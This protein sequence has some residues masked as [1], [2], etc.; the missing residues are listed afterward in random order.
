MRIIP[1]FSILSL[2]AIIAPL[3]RAQSDPNLEIGLKP[4]GAYQMGNIDNVSLGNGS[5]AVDIPLISY[6]QRGGKLKLDF[7]L[8]YFD[9]AYYEEY[10][11][12]TKYCGWAP[13]FVSAGMA[14][15]DKQE[16]STTFTAASNNGLSPNLFGT[17]DYDGA[18][19]SL[20]AT[21]TNLL[22]SV[23]AS[24]YQ[25]IGGGT[26]Y[27]LTSVTDKDG[28][29]FT[30]VGATGCPFGNVGYSVV[31]PSG[32]GFGSTLPRVCTGPRSDP[33]GNKISFS[34]S[35]G[36]TDTMGRAIPLPTK[37]TSQSDF[38]GCTGS[39]TTLFVLLW[40]PPGL[41]GGTY[42]L[43]FCYF[44][45]NTTATYG[46]NQ[47]ELQSVVL[48]DN[49]A[50]TFQYT[51][52]TGSID[53][54]IS[55]ITFPTG[56]TLSYTWTTIA[57]CQPPNQNQTDYTYAVVTRTL[58]PNDGVTP[59]STWTYT[60][61]ASSYPVQ[62]IVSAPP[63]IGSTPD[64]TVHTIGIGTSPQCYLYETQAQSYQG[65]HTSG[66]L[67][68]TT[69]TTYQY[70]TENTGS[71]ATIVNIAPTKVTTSWANGQ[72]SQNSFT[73]D[74]AYSFYPSFGV[75]ISPPYTI[76][77]NGTKYQGTYG[78]NLTK[79]EYD[80][81]SG[82]PGA[83][84]R[85]TTTAYLALSNSTY[86]NANLL[87]LPSSVQVTGSGPGSNTTYNYDETG[88]PAGAHGNL[89]STHRWLN[90][91][92]T[93]LVASNVY[94]SNGL[95]TSTTDPKN[96]PPTTY[97][98]SP[99][100]CPA[101]SGYAGDGP[102]SVTNA[103]G[104]T[105]Y[106]CYDLNTGPLISTTD[107]NGETTSY[108]Y[109]DMIRTTQISY[110]D[111]G[112]TTFT[113]FP[114]FQGGAYVY[115]AEKMDTSGDSRDI[116]EWVDGVGRKGRVSISNGETLDYDETTDICYNGLGQVAFSAYPF[117]D[118]GWSAP[119]S[120]TI[121][122]DSF[123]YD[124]LGRTT[125]VTHSDGSSVLTSYTGR[126]TSVSDEGNGNGTQRVQRVS[127]VDGL[128]RLT[129]LCEVTNATL[130][131]GISGSTT[132]AACGQDIAETGF[133]TTYAYD[134]LNDPT[135]VTQGPLNP[136]TFVY[137]SLARL[138]SGANPE[139]G[140]T[141]YTYDADS[142]LLTKTDARSITTTYAYDKLNRML[143]KIH[144]DG[145]IQANFQYDA[146][147][148]WGV[149]L[150]NPIGRL[151][152]KW[153]S[154]TISDPT[155]SIFGYD[156]MG[157]LAQEIDCT[158][159]YCPSSTAS[160]FTLNYTY[161]LLGDMHSLTGVGL[162]LNY[163]Y[164]AGARLTTLTNNASG[165]PPPATLFS[166]AHYNGAGSLVS[167]TLGDGVNE[168]RSYD[169][170]LRL[171][172]IADGSAYNLIIPSSTPSACIS[173]STA[174][175]APNSDVLVASDS[176]NLNWTYSY[177]AFNRLTGSNQ[178]S[179]QNVFSYVYDR[180][181]NR[182]QQNVTAGG[183]PGPRYSFTAYNQ[184]AAGSGVTYDAAGNT[185][186]DGVHQY[187]YDA[188]DRIKQVDGTLG[189]CS[190]P[191]TA[192]YTYDAD[193]RRAEKVT[194]GTTTDFLY[195]PSGHEIAA[196]NSSGA[197]TRE[198]VYAGNRHLVSYTNSPAT[199]FIYSDWLGTER[200]RSPYSGGSNETCKS[201]PFGDLLTCTGTD[202][203]PMHFTGQERDTESNLDNFHARYD[204]SSMGRFISPDPANASVDFW[205]PQTWNRY[206]YVLNN[207]LVVVDRNGQWP[208]PIHNE[209]INQAFPGMSASDRGILKDASKEVDTHQESYNS[210]MHG[211]SDG[212]DPL[213][214]AHAIGLSEQLGD[215]QILTDEAEARSDQA[216]WVAEGH[217]GL[218][219]LALQKFGN[220]LHIITDRLS[221]AHIGYQP[222]YGQA[223][224][225][226]SALLHGVHES[227]PW[228]PNVGFSVQ[229]AQNAFRE[230]FGVQM[231][232]Y[233]ELQQKS[234]RGWGTGRLCGPDLPG[235][236]VY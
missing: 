142:N 11:C 192:C 182:W 66:A 3:V 1:V 95:V 71:P 232:G 226:P 53:P 163:S 59:A 20:A 228:H 79:Q 67:L 154:T 181:G 213:G 57:P 162:T 37:S 170:R 17:T 208:W 105:T 122:G 180:F 55:Q 143:S 82:A 101:N 138:T 29:T 193:G 7:S 126:A 50:W 225:Y 120:C 190:A 88:S 146:A 139:S 179:G 12:Y 188:E 36:W 156:P 231:F 140:T 129:S 212:N 234:L 70:V 166:A 5:L 25:A 216:E 65:S 100:S 77:P 183:G 198:E 178:N 169:P 83:I 114:V 127:Q 63:S 219:P 211:M 168:S 195:D 167:A 214:A 196:V 18:T 103:L 80:Y 30:P 177:D 173:G 6:P 23:D 210:W 160:R 9:A 86:L 176:V 48:P 91:T 92:G 164:N 42:P 200:V 218:S 124:G 209:I 131:V 85:T 78:L 174:G 98:Y 115:I 33:N 74:S 206:S 97:G 61:V 186:D 10:F 117:Q 41:N 76:T 96:N 191:T 113:Y 89:T 44:A 21:G 75:P 93:Y 123:T 24:G 233:L 112:L 151:T 224:W 130:S 40:N 137:D 31:D 135:S 194:G 161:D 128:G 34:T 221:P 52:S 158:P 26:N 46:Y 13:V 149:T 45:E 230:T 28:V 215:K 229:A 175:Y 27:P 107:P 197:W 147:S 235:C 49:T 110:P 94:N 39:Q 58:N 141:T 72:T 60:Y 220:A 38:S 4:F 47:Y 109:D 87:D 15:V 155:A 104:Q 16:V 217:T 102:T 22:E 81:G 8:H 207:P 148:N 51:V 106:Y 54:S 90:T 171:C 133:L 73:Y 204:S 19:H 68:K 134:V 99:S 159:A 69:N 14:V 62:T 172:A 2:L 150:T 199:F 121:A 202:V 189:S 184:I 205:L 111:R 157:R 145:T 152:E 84:L 64:D 56:G 32:G 203:S 227:W 35:S 144:S 118:D 222:W 187:F 116:T 136:R 236:V 153:T 132:P 108:Q 125:S 185:N 43:K 201:L 165:A 223:K 119:R